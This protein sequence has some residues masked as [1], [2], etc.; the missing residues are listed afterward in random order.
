MTPDMS[1]CYA[2][3]FFLKCVFTDITLKGNKTT[4]AGREY[5]YKGYKI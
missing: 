5:K 2:V 4:G 3:H 1:S